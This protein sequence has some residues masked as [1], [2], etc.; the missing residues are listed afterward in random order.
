MSD[1]NTIGT[2]RICSTADNVRLNSERWQCAHTPH[3]RTHTHRHTNET[4]AALCRQDKDQRRCEIN[5][6]VPLHL[7]VR[8]F[9]GFFSQA[10]ALRRD[11]VIV[12]GAHILVRIVETAWTGPGWRPEQETKKMIGSTSNVGSIECQNLKNYEWLLTFGHI[13]LLFCVSQA[14]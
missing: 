12:F 6:A 14:R 5:K 11:Q 10:G 9:R 3:T 7:W 4:N 8:D 13:F 1:T 2:D